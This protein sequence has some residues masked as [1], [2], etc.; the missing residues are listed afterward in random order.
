MIKDLLNGIEIKFSEKGK[1]SPQQV[2]NNLKRQATNYLANL[3]VA[4]GDT[5]LG[6]DGNLIIKVNADGADGNQVFVK[7]T[8][9]VQTQKE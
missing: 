1:L 2:G 9:V 3:L 8:A 7:V 5:V 6:E 4:N